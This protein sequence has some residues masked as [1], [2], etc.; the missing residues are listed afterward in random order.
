MN[1][2]TLIPSL[3]LA[4]GLAFASPGQAADGDHVWSQGYNAGGFA[5]LDGSNNAYVSGTFFG[6]L[7][8]G[9]G[10]MN[11]VNF[12]NGDVFLAKLDVNG[13]HVWSTSFVPSFGVFI[14][15]VAV[16]P[17]GGTYVAGK[18]LN[19]DV[20]FGGG[21]I[22]GTNEIV[23]VKFDANGNHVWDS[24]FGNGE[25]YEMDADGTHLAVC[26]RIDTAVDF[27]GGSLSG[28]GG[29]DGF[30]A[31]LTAAGGHV[32]SLG[33]GD[34]GNEEGRNV[35][36][37]S[38]GD[39]SLLAA[40]SGSAD[41]G[42]GALTADFNVD[43]AL[44]RF[45]A[46]GTHLW[47]TIYHGTFS[48]GSYVTA[49][50]LAVGPSD[51]I[52]ITGENRAAVDFGGGNL[53]TVGQA[54]IFLVKLDSSGSHVW[55]TSLG[56]TSTDI[57]QGVACD[58]DGNILLTGQFSDTVDFGGGPVVATGFGDLFSA[59][60][61]A[62]GAHRWSAGYG[63]GYTC[64]G[65]F[66]SDGAALLHGGGSGSLDFGGGALGSANFFLVRLEG[67]GG[68]GTTDVPQVAAGAHV[69]LESFP[70]PFRPR[71]TIRFSLVRSASVDLSVYDLA[72]RRIRTLSRRSHPAGAHVVTWDGRTDRGGRAPAG[73]YFARLVTPEGTETRRM[74]R[75]N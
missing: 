35:A 20:D 48:G 67:S 61:D 56:A 69:G 57:G 55:S 30:V 72:G 10:V 8:F 21:T 11:S 28:G 23:I 34:G 70:N 1:P 71:T 15:A 44:A 3:A 45:D 22:S 50:D 65:T 25:V 19:G 37:G 4:A 24:T 59:S 41:F 17:A 54:D 40:V 64:L 26:G 36:L 53:N 27:G 43:I 13:D 39:I 31:K 62:A 16:D 74:V 63:N 18:I 60:Y 38:G 68:G 47:S 5:D 75:V 6:S 49:A 14:D 29:R 7:D 32:W 73:V 2:R 42:G 9:G 51:E 66:Y 33:F 12:L 58:S 46:S 52:V